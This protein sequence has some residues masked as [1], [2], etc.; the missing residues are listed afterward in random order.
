MGNLHS[1][2]GFLLVVGGVLLAFL[3]S[4]FISSFTGAK[5]LV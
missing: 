4:P 3:L 1:V 5:G 2:W